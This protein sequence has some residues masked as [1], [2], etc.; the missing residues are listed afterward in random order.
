M[1]HYGQ[2]ERLTGNDAQMTFLLRRLS[3]GPDVRVLTSW[4]TRMSN[5]R[6]YRYYLPD[7]RTEDRAGESDLRRLPAAEARG[8]GA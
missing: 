2:P 5:N 1:R 8:G 4:F 7:A 6:R 3:S